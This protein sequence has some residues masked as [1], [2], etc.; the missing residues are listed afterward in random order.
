MTRNK[1][2]CKLKGASSAGPLCYCDSKNR[3]ANRS[4]FHQ[5]SQGCARDDVGD[6]GRGAHREL[7]L[8]TRPGTCRRSPFLLP[9]RVVVPA[10]QLANCWSDPK[11]ETTSVAQ[12]VG[13]R[14]RF[15]CS[16]FGIAQ[17]H[18]FSR[19]SHIPSSRWPVPTNVLADDGG[20]DRTCLDHK[21]QN[22][23]DYLEFHA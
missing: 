11:I 3:Q 6:D 16:Y 21:R 2:Q 20:F 5:L 15:G 4:Q 17:R 1:T 8:K 23:S 18:Y 19:Y 14:V 22:S 7:S 9:G 12:F 10:Q 13:C